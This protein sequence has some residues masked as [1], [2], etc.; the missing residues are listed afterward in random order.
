MEEYVQKIKKM[1][2][3]MLIL[4]KDT[5]QNKN[6]NI[7]FLDPIESQLKINDKIVK[8]SRCEYIVFKELF[9]APEHFCTHEKLCNKLYDCSYEKYTS[10]SLNKVVAQLRKKLNGIAK[11]NNI[12]GKGYKMEM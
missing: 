12:F 4:Y 5:E 7:P 2:D 10:K 11:I 8:L 1:L 3:D 9:V 6:V